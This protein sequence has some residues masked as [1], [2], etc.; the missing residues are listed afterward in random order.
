MKNRFEANYKDREYVFGT[1]EELGLPKISAMIVELAQDLLEFAESEEEQKKKVLSFTIMAWNLAVI[2]ECE[3]GNIMTYTDEFHHLFGIDRNSKVGENL[4][5]LFLVLVAAKYFKYPGIHSYIA[6]FEITKKK[7]EL[8]LNV[9]SVV[10][11]PPEPRTESFL[12]KLSQHVA[13]EKEKTYKK[14]LVV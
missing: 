14:V 12:A 6:D 8:N 13:V 9:V 11:A 1:S 2:S 3:E 7:G 4:T 10:M 5:G